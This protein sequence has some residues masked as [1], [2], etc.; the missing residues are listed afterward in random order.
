MALHQSTTPPTV[1]NEIPSTDIDP[2]KSMMGLNSFKLKKDFQK[3]KRILC[4]YKDQ[5][6]KL[7][8]LKKTWSNKRKSSWQ[9]LDQSKMNFEQFEKS[10]LSFEQVERPMKRIKIFFVLLPKKFC[11]I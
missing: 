6:K 9:S 3:P 7:K 11:K 2:K 5:W 4:Q 8:N 1:D 10:V